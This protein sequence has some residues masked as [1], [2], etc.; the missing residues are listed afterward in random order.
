MHTHTHTH[1]HTLAPSP[2]HSSPCH[3]HT[4]T[5]THTRSS[6]STPNPPPHTH[7]HTHTLFPPSVGY[8]HAIHSERS[9][10]SAGN[11][12]KTLSPPPLA[13]IIVRGALPP[14]PLPPH[15]PPPPRPSRHSHPQS[16]LQPHPRDTATEVRS[17]GP[18]VDAVC[19]KPWSVTVAAA[20]RRPTDAATVVHSLVHVK[21]APFFCGCDTVRKLSLTG[22]LLCGTD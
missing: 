8:Y 14:P 18:S 16:S 12:R 19:G 21:P 11:H 15:H 4:H 2:L 10:G 17:A 9:A 7:T 22:R 6:P 1:T 5:H 3:T 20:G 13:D